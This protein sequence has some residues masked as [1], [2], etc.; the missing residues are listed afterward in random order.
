MEVLIPH[1]VD[2]ALASEPDTLI[3]SVWESGPSKLEKAL[4]LALHEVVFFV[5]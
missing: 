4:C 1:F 3:N 5:F 2:K